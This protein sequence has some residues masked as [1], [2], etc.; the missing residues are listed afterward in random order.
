MDDEYFVTARPEPDQDR[1]DDAVLPRRTAEKLA[2]RDL[3]PLLGT[4]FVEPRAVRVLRRTG[5][6]LLGVGIL[7]LGA[8][9]VLG[10]LAIRELFES[11]PF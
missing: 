9:P 4:P 1:D 11:L 5:V 7:A 8:L 10:F 2:E 6:A 3:A